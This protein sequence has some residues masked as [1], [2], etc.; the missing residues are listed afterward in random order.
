M[1][2]S[3]LKIVFLFLFSCFAKENRVLVSSVPVEYREVSSASQTEK[4]ES[5]ISREELLED[6]D[7]FIYFLKTA[8]IGYDDLVKNGFDE[9]NFKSYFEGLYKKQGQVDTYDLLKNLAVYLIPYPEDCHFTIS[10]TANKE[11]EYLISNSKI[12]FSDIFIEKTENAFVAFETGNSGIKKGSEYTGS[13]E[14]AFYYPSKGKNIYRLGVLSK[15]TLTKTAFSFNERSIEAAVSTDK[16][17]PMQ[18]FVKYHEIET[19]NSAYASL[20]S[21]LQPEADSQFR[22]GADIVFEKFAN[23]GIKWRTKNN[24]IIDL[25]SNIGGRMY[26]SRAF[27]YSFLS[28]KKHLDLLKEEKTIDSWYENT[29]CSHLQLESPAYLQNVLQ[30]IESKGLTGTSY[31]KNY[32]KQLTSQKKNPVVN[33]YKCE[34]LDSNRFSSDFNGNLIILTDRNTASASEELILFAKKILKTANVTVI[35]EN[36]YGC[37]TYVDDLVYLF[38]NSHLSVCL[39]A[40]KNTAIS[41]LPEWHGE[42]KGIFPDYWTTS[43]DLNKTILLTTHDEEMFTKLQGIENRL[44]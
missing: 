35:G 8:Y 10:G 4:R 41:T 13:L 38:P 5:F 6:L 40:R 27:V 31:Y 15:E 42:G 28:K 2:K 18:S 24:I 33:I 39:G 3:I 32:Q 16:E 30:Y 43:E 12:Y 9:N 25:R 19:Q 17:F 7:S 23:L 26:Y 34:K 14:N 11:Y 21:F 20:S 1:K 22:K 29:L 36:S 37:D 44:M